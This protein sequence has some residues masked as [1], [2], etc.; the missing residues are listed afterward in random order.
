MIRTMIMFPFGRPI[1][2]VLHVGLELASAIF[3]ESYA[4]KHI[5]C[6]HLNLYLSTTRSTFWAANRFGLGLPAVK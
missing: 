6:F 4:G 1:F 2:S 3:A 5:F